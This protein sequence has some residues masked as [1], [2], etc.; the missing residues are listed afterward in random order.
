MFLE[1]KLKVTGGRGGG[2]EEGKEQ[3]S[4]VH[5]LAYYKILNAQDM[6]YE[7]NIARM[8]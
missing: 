8:T 4:L 1:E 7:L 2:I 6:I 5:H 3:V